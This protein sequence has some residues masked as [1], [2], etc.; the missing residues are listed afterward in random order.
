VA[1][2][3]A[4]AVEENRLPISG[5]SLVGVYWWEVTTSESS[6]LVVGPSLITLEV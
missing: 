5:E 1:Q 6:D 3:G 4:S 2:E